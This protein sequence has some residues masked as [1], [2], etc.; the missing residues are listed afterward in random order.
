MWVEGGGGGRA[1]KV[2]KFYHYGFKLEKEPIA[3]C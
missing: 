3:N 1:G 2:A